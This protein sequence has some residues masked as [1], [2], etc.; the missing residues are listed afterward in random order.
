MSGSVH[1]KIA[2]GNV[3]AATIVISTNPYSSTSAETGIHA[4][5]R[6]A[7]IFQSARS[8]RTVSAI[9]NTW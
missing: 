7:F 6:G 8:H 9:V 4:S 5:N 2:C 1:N 3:T